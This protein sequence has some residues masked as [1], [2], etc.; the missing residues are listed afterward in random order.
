[1]SDPHF[2]AFE[3]RPLNL[4]ARLHVASRPLEGRVV[5]LGL[6]GAGLETRGYVPVGTEVELELETPT[7]WEPLRF[8]AT[9]TWLRETADG[10]VLG[11]CFQHESSR[12]AGSLLGLLH[13]EAY[14]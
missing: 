5:N 4:P 11:L 2:R 14:S 13:T 10:F 9:V 12:A 6:G 1:V 7:L 8:E 3:R